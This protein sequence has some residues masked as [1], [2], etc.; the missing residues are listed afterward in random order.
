MELSVKDLMIGDWV[1][2][3]YPAL[4]EGNK[5]TIAEIHP[6]GVFSPKD[7]RTYMMR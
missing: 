4:G 2:I 5:T 3:K 1:R 7:I 6:K